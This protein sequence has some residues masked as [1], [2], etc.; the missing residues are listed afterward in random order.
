MAKKNYTDVYDSMRSGT[1]TGGGKLTMGAIKDVK[2]TG[3]KDFIKC[4]E[5]YDK[6]FTP[7]QPSAPSETKVVLSEEN[8]KEMRLRRMGAAQCIKERL[9]EGFTT[10]DID[11]LIL[12]IQ[13]IVKSV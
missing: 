13:E 5:A 7:A 10:N 6:V 3:G 11:Q 8:M 1:A 9:S 12:D 2:P 4:Q